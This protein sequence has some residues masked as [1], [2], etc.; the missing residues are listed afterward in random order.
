LPP[1]ASTGREGNVFGT[2]SNLGNKNLRP[3]GKYDIMCFHNL[4]D[5]FWRRN[6]D[7]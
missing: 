1:I 4:F 5:H 3:I 6:C 7:V 2:V